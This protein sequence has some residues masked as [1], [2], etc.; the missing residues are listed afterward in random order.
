MAPRVAIVYVSVTLICLTPRLDWL[1]RARDPQ[2]ELDKLNGGD[3][4]PLKPV[5]L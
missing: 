3:G 2:A 4:G 5:R 1:Q